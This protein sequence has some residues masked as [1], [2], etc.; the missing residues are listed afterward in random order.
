ML[1]C[2][3]FTVDDRVRPVVVGILHA[4]AMLIH[5]LAFLYMPALAVA[6]WHQ[7][8]KQG[9]QGN[10]KCVM[11]FALTALTITTLVYYISFIYQFHDYSVLGLLRWVTSYAQDASFSF[12][13]TKNVA[14]S[15]LGNLRLFWGG[16]LALVSAVWNPFVAF[17]AAGVLAS[18]GVFVYSLRKQ[19]RVTMPFKHRSIACVSVVWILTYSIFLLFWL[20]HNTFYRLFYIPAVL[21]LIS[22]VLNNPQ[23]RRLLLGSAVAILFFWN[24]GFVIYPYSQPRLN[25]ALTIAHTLQKVWP[26]GT[27]VYWDVYASDNRV[28]QYF[29]PQVTWKPLWGRA[30]TE[31]LHD[32][33]VR[34][35]AQSQAVWFDSNALRIYRGQDPNFDAW[36]RVNCRID[37]EEEFT[38][39]D[40]R[41]GFARLSLRSQ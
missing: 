26:M 17:T 19:P 12:N 18:A 23:Q 29:N 1:T 28:V 10:T 5:E 6:L 22:T 41:V 35:Q 31:E 37:V 38:N 27:I 4:A 15:L 16:R 14:A 8:A 25:T 3:L 36:F 33:I 9:R 2:L 30:W 24:A 39:G 11:Q 13:I 21:L 40:H 34:T 7:Q 20:P 32:T